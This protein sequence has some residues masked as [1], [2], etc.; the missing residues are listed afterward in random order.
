[1]ETTLVIPP[2][3]FLAGVDQHERID[4]ADLLELVIHESGAKHVVRSCQVCYQLVKKSLVDA[5]IGKH[6]AWDT[7][8][9]MW[10]LLPMFDYAGWRAAAI[11]IWSKL[12]GKHT[13]IRDPK[14]FPNFPRFV[15]WK[16][17][18]KLKEVSLAAYREESQRWRAK[19]GV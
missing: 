6:M 8:E 13:H 15:K 12:V 2:L 9:E 16:A 7:K 1:M 17:V 4:S 10:K 19:K 14:A 11:P 18:Y 3:R 5:Y